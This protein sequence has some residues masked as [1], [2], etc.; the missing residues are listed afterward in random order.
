MNILIEYIIYIVSKINKTMYA[1]G[2]HKY[3]QD[4]DYSTS[5]SRSENSKPWP[6]SCSASTSVSCLRSSAK[7]SCP[8]AG[9][10]TEAR[11]S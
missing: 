6:G 3:L 11:Q 8:E 9:R 5:S 10:Q 2:E 4:L 1:Q 7:A